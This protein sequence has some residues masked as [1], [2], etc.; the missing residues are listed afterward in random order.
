MIN[1]MI[2]VIMTTGIF[3][4]TSLVGFLLL[5]IL[6]SHDKNKKLNELKYLESLDS[7]SRHN[8]EYWKDY[9]N[10]V[11]SIT[12]NEYGTKY[13]F[14]TKNFENEDIII[15]L[16][17]YELDPK[18]FMNTLEIISLNVKDSNGYQYQVL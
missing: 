15:D 4:L 1:M 2:T 16:M 11:K 9:V 6:G 3:G 13:K 14:V 12:S 5:G 17:S 7:V 10:E 18:E 8:Y